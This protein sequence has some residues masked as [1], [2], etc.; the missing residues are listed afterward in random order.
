MGGVSGGGASAKRAPWGSL[1]AVKV[2]WAIVPLKVRNPD[3]PLKRLVSAALWKPGAAVSVICGKYAALA[4]PICAL[5][6]I[7]NCSDRRMSGRRSRSD[8]GSPGGTSGG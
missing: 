6:A 5:A 1:P 8:D 2:G 4:T 7:I 3:A